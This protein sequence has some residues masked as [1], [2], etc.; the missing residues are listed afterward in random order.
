MEFLKEHFGD[1][2]EKV[3]LLLDDFSGHWTPEV[4]E[5][6]RALNII[7]MKVP[8]GCTAV[9][10]P[11]DVAWMKPFKGSI[12]E[13]WVAFLRGALRSNVP[14]EPFRLARPSR[15]DVT[16]WI[17]SAWA[18]LK[19]STIVN[20]FSKIG[21]VPRMP[22]SRTPSTQQVREPDATDVINQL[23]SLGLVDER[24]GDID[25][26]EDIDVVDSMDLLAI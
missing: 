3:I 21:V 13:S 9:C 24:V 10:Q 1:N 26:D 16:D 2:N 18:V 20:G 23:S 7:L 11:A 15:T 25:S 17:R 5:Q 22:R 12:R 14:G 6:A 8:P 19:D 4:I